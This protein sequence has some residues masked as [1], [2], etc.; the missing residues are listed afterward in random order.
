MFVEREYVAARTDRAQIHGETSCARGKFFG[1]VHEFPAKAFALLGRIDA[2]QPQIHPVL[3]LFKVDATD[4]TIFFFEKQ[5]FAGTEIFQR[6]GAV[7]AV[8]A[9]ERT[10]DCKCGVNEPRKGVGV[11]ILRNANRNCGSS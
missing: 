1:C 4:K 5:E 10:L 9:E 11:R 2:E 7:E 6:A 8:A 3:A